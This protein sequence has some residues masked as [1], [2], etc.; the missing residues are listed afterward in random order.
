MIINALLT[1]KCNLRCAYCKIV[2]NNCKE[3]PAKDWFDFLKRMQ[4]FTNGNLFTIL[5]G[6]EPTV[7][8]DFDNLMSLVTDS[9]LEYT[10]ITNATEYARKK[11]EPWISKMK[12]LTSSVDPLMFIENGDFDKD[13]LL[14]SN[15]GLS[16]LINGKE[17]NP[18]I[19]A[20]AEVVVDRYSYKGLPKLLEILS[21]YG[22]WAS[23]TII[24][25]SKTKDYDFA[26]CEDDQLMTE[27]EL[28]ELMQII[29]EAVFIKRLIIHAPEAIYTVAS[30][31]SMNSYCKPYLPDGSKNSSPVNDE[32]ITVD[33]DGTMRLCLR[34]HGKES[35][36]FTMYDLPEKYNE[37][38]E[39]NNKDYRELCKGCS[40]TCPFMHN[41]IHPVVLPEQAIKG[42]VDLYPKVEF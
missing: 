11:I 18:E 41:V 6:G 34:M 5:Y 32:T 4:K 15:E 22:I 13:R 26:T 17:K 21:K 25:N 3:L 28:K 42:F 23:I 27:K 19:D 35:N 24:E 10:V 12:G 9:D 31:G 30:N 16:F 20:V 40:W 29:T 36:K 33:S 37:F 2:R 38:M 39:A 14:K 8:H 7:Y 1:R